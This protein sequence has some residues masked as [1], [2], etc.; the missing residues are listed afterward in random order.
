ML[1]NG[2]A[3]FACIIAPEVMRRL[4]IN[5]ATIYNYSKPVIFGEHRM[6][7]RPRDSHDLRLLSATLTIDPV[8][9]SVR[10]LHDVFSNS[11]AVA[12]FTQQAAA[13]KIE[14]LSSSS[15]S[16]ARNLIIPSR[17]MPRRIHSRT[18]PRRFLTCTARWNGNTRCES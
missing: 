17:P 11:V 6:M 18:R 14:S 16:K 2:F 8:P 13:L 9:E 10:W 5:H 4:T 1:G 3:I 12:S 15:I 7:L